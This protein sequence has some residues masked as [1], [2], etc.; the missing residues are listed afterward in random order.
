MQDTPRIGGKASRPPDYAAYAFDAPEGRW[1]GRLDS[2]RWGK[3]A[4]N[5]PN[6]VC[7][8]TDV[9][10]GKQYLF[11]AFKSNGYGPLSGEPSFRQERPGTLYRMSTGKNSKGKPIWHAA[12]R[13][14]SGHCAESR[15]SAYS[16]QTSV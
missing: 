16:A 10:T 13:V 9:A 12:T 8:F 15:T 5:V 4:N 14:E 6:L 3:K 1:T 11:S 2:V 7:Y